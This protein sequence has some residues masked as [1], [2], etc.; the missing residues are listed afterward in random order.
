MGVSELAAGARPLRRREQSRDLAD[1]SR[2]F[3]RTLGFSMKD[4]LVRDRSRA[5]RRFKGS[6][7]P[8]GE[9]NNLRG[10]IHAKREPVTDTVRDDAFALAAP[11]ESGPIAKHRASKS[12]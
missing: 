5:E 11:I 8:Q 2:N 10:R 7:S 6:L 9:M 1:Q 4:R 3:V 12:Y